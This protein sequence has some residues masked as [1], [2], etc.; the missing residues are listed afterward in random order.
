MRDA[1]RFVLSILALLIVSPAA[2]HLTP[3]SEVNLDVGPRGVSADIIVPQGEYAYASGNPTGNDAASLALARR[4]LTDRFAVAAPSG[5][6]WRIA[7]DDIEFAQIAGPPD[8]HATATL[9]PPAGS[10]GRSFTIDWRVV[11]DRVPDHFALFKLRRDLA[12]TV[13]GDARVLGA[14]RAASPRIA[15]DLGDPHIATMVGNAMLLGAHHIAGGYDH[16][17]F[18]LALL[19]PAP[20]IARSGGWKG[21]VRTHRAT[22]HGLLWIVSAFTIGHSLTLIG[23]SLLGWSLPVAPVEIA[24]AASVMVSAAHALRPI[25]P[26]REPW[27]AAGFGLIHGLAFATLVAGAGTAMVGSGWMLLGFNLGIEGVQIAMVLAML[28][29]LLWLAPSPA[30]RIVRI[31]GGALGIAMAALWIAN[32]ALGVFGGLVGALE[33][34]LIAA[35]FALLATAIAAWLLARRRGPA[36]I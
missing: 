16:L 18:L 8:L 29:V 36:V 21:G 5:T 32:R 10:S 3:N 9:T 22:L 27:V 33:H 30:Y 19:L 20:L 6:R 26:G 17:L 1:V 12:G 4:Y 11:V 15:V 25:F 2:A 31:G 23:A 35:W 28:P 14:V 34:G 24:I 13:G 7:I